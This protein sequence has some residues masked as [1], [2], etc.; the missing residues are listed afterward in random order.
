MPA[1]VSEFNPSKVGL[2]SLVYSTVLES[3]TSTAEDDSTPTAIAAA[4][5]KIY[6]TGYTE[7]GFPISSNAFQ[8]TYGGGPNGSGFVTE[9]QSGR[10]RR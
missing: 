7:P 2:D 9:S 6:V 3:G 10:H 4:G 1:F 5:G 8:K